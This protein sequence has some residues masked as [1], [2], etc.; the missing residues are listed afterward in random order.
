MRLDASAHVDPCPVVDAGTDPTLLEIVRRGIEHARRRCRLVR[1]GRANESD[2]L[3]MKKPI[4]V[5]TPRQM[6]IMPH[7]DRTTL[8]IRHPDIHEAWIEIGPMLPGSTR[9]LTKGLKAHVAADLM[10]DAAEVHLHGLTNR[11]LDRDETERRRRLLHAIA[12]HVRMRADDCGRCSTGRVKAATPW[13]PLSAPMGAVESDPQ[14]NALK[15]DERL[16]WTQEPVVALSN[17]FITRMASG[18][19][20]V[21]V[22]TLRIDALSVPTDPQASMVDDMRRLGDLVPPPPVRRSPR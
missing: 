5:D 4:R 7:G 6:L 8:Q 22:A 10:L 1:A 12:V 21:R 17:G 14:Y 9:L 18:Q 2:V 13:S 16:L 20:S 3:I 15:R 11:L 19:P